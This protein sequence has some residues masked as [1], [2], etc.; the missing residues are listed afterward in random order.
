[1]TRPA[2]V[3]VN[4]PS[5]PF[6]ADIFV[7]DLTPRERET[8]ILVASGLT[9]QDIAKRMGVKRTSADAYVRRALEKLGFA[10]RVQA[11]LYI[12]ATEM[13]SLDAAYATMKGLLHPAPA[14]AGEKP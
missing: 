8:L 14:R 5:L 12:L 13:V 1:M 2:I 3:S 11:T 6:V 4:D 9:N 7:N 10:N